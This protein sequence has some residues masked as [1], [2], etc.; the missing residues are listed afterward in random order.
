MAQEDWASVS[1]AEGLYAWTVCL[2][3]GGEITVT[4]AQET[5]DGPCLLGRTQ[6]CPQEPA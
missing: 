4:G 5:A 2:S 6:D 1:W 3:E